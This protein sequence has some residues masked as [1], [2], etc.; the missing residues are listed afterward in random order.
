MLAWPEY[1][2]FLHT[3]NMAFFCIADNLHS[4]NYLA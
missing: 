3:V 4:L 2:G 1:A